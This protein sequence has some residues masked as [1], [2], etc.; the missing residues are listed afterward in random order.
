MATLE[1]A[2]TAELLATAGVTAV[3]GTRIW[4]Q[5]AVQATTSPYIVLDAVSKRP[6]HD[7][8]GLTGL[9]Q[10]RVSASCYAPTYAD[11]KAAAAAV[12]AALDRRRG[13][14]QGV[15]FG[16]ILVESEEDAGWDDATKM[17]VVAVDLRVLV[18]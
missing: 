8:G 5:V 16:A 15:T 1:T 11:A 10:A 3:V 14:I 17:H 9:T 2:L 4:W 18:Q 12:A 13:T 6:V 7:M